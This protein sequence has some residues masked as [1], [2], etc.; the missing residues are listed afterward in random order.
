[1]NVFFEAEPSAAIL[2]A[3]RT[4]GHSQK[5]DLGEGWGALMIETE[6]QV[7]PTTSYM[8]WGSAVGSPQWGT[9]AFWTH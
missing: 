6:Q 3:H 1:V 8:V 2:I 7:P 5:F 4:H 9:N